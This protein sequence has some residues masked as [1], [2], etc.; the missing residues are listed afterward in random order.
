VCVCSLRYT[1]SKK[2]TPT[3]SKMEMYSAG[4]S[5]DKAALADACS[6]VSS[7]ERGPVHRPGTQGMA[8]SFNP[9][10]Q[11]VASG[12]KLDFGKHRGQLVC[13]VSPQYVRW[14]VK[15]G[16]HTNRPDLHAALSAHGFLGTPS[17]SGRR[18]C[19]CNVSLIKDTETGAHLKV[20]ILDRRIES[21]ISSAVKQVQEQDAPQLLPNM[22]DML[23]HKHKLSA[24][25]GLVLHCVVQSKDPK[26]SQFHS[27]SK[28]TICANEDENVKTLKETPEEWLGFDA[29]SGIPESVST[30]A[31]AGVGETAW[32]SAAAHVGKLRRTTMT[33]YFPRTGHIKSLTGIHTHSPI[34]L[35][36]LSHTPPADTTLTDERLP[37]PSP[38]RTRAAGRMRDELSWIRSVVTTALQH[39]PEPLGD[40]AR[41]SSLV[42]RFV[43]PLPSLAPEYTTR[44]AT[45]LRLIS[46]LGFEDCFLQ[47][48]L[49]IQLRYKIAT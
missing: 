42:S 7:P 25:S 41:N 24:E 46:E 40:I 23:K 13:Q 21:S 45:E 11:G 29:V 43:R 26:E 2:C 28:E 31:P 27:T 30:K 35:H 49:C 15:N 16:I 48:C 14:M 18:G 5:G 34:H 8:S 3:L 6:E 38:R 4:P 22:G 32:Q 33:E 10:M 47:V 1:P 9:G 37:T 44:L 12:F 39:A 17:F 19:V 36:A 20:H